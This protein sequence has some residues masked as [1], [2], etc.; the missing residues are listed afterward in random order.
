MTR[1]GAPAELNAE[2][3]RALNRYFDANW[4]KHTTPVFQPAQV[5]FESRELGGGT[6]YVLRKNGSRLVLKMTFII[7]GEAPFH[8]Y[9]VLG[10]H[11]PR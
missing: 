6:N 7:R 8:G 1:P 3:V 5:T 11:R 9:A 10:E 4:E 2:R